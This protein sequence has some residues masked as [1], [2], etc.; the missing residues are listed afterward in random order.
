MRLYMW[1]YV[2]E[3][4][5]RIEGRGPDINSFDME[6]YHFNNTDIHT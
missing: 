1:V 6:A 2:Y 3:L 4:K 5:L